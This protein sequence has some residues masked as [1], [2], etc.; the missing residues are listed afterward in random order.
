M[1]VPMA[2]SPPARPVAPVLSGPALARVLEPEVM[3]TELEA[4]DYDQ[5]DHREVNARFVDDLTSLSVDLTRVL[6][7]GTGTAQIAVALCKRARGAKVVAIDLAHHMLR[8]GSHNVERAGLAGVISLEH[9]D[10]KALDLPDASFTCIM[11]NSIVHHIPSPLGALVEMVR[12]LAPSGWLFVRDL[13]RPPD[14]VTVMA[15]VERYAKNENAHQKALFEASL[16]AALSSGEM[17]D[18]ARRAGIDPASVSQ[19]SDRH[20]TLAWRKP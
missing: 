18:L 7:V 19:T 12:V 8:L 11:S 15:L 20:W 6:D 2:S 5:M 4:S 3:D 10:A 16:R 13:L 9:R 1:P 17:A 14:D